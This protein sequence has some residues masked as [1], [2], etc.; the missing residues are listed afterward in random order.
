MHD[1]AEIKLKEAWQLAAASRD[2]YAQA[3]VSLGLAF[4]DFQRQLNESC[5]T[6]TSR[7]LRLFQ[8]VSTALGRY[9]EIDCWVRLGMLYR[10][11]GDYKSAI[12]TAEEG[13]KVAKTNELVNWQAELQSGL[14]FHHRA[15]GQFEAAMKS[16]EEALRLFKEQCGM[17]REEAV[18][19]SYIGNLFIEMGLFEE[20]KRSFEKAEEMA[21]SIN[22]RR[23]LS[24]IL[25][26]KGILYCRLGDYQNALVL[27]EC[28]LKIAKENSH[29]DS[30]VVR[31][32]DR[33][34]TLLAMGRVKDAQD[35][36]RDALRCAAEDEKKD[37]PPDLPAAFL[38][39]PS[40]EDKLPHE[41]QSP[42]DHERRGILLTRIYLRS[43]DLKNAAA[44][45]ERTQAVEHDSSPHRHLATVIHAIVLHRLD[46]KEAAKN[47]YQKALE[48]AM[49]IQLRAQSYYPAEYSRALA[50]SG[51]AM[52][53]DDT[54]RPTCMCQAQA[55]FQRARAA[56]AAAG[57]IGDA[58]SVLR[59][60]PSQSF[61]P[62]ML[63]PDEAPLWGRP[64]AI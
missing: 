7:A 30:Q 35:S 55:A 8:Q 46:E 41:M 57:V 1:A 53:C 14:G 10:K 5:L 49:D 25:A 59:E 42:H 43:G 29:L 19:H 17:K 45:I 62:G 63:L 33:A 15:Q 50:L 23:E 60:I 48:Q 28:S 32:T 36:L 18:Q 54:Q 11:M 56:C 12:S 44:A 2:P 37:R 34:A 6:N 13:L 38:E 31:F 39:A 9:R 51:L 24:W 47:F 26:N 27:Q 21:R 22:I 64:G 40:L 52:L 61:L 20:A 16:H 3:H 58:I 4:A